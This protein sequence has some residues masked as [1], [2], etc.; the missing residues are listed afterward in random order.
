MDRIISSVP[1]NGTAARVV[2]KGSRYIQKRVTNHL[3][4]DICP[5]LRQ[6]L[7]G[8]LDLTGVKFGK[9]VVV[10]LLYFDRFKQKRKKNNPARWVCKCECGRF[11][12]RHAKTIKKDASE[13]DRCQECFN[14]DV[15]KA[16]YK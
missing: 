13:N 9:F 8:A 10:G 1:I 15:L 3:H 4:W 16:R 2:A 14:V 11:E 5:K 7:H 6:P 12:A